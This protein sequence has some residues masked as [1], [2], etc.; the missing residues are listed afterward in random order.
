MIIYGVFHLKALT[1]SP[2]NSL[3]LDEITKLAQNDVENLYTAGVDGIIIENFKT[4]LC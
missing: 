4:I 1:G 3:G 2:S